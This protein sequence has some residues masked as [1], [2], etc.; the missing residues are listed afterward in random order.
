MP[1][2][3]TDTRKDSL[4]LATACIGLVAAAVLWGLMLD[5][6]LPLQPDSVDFLIGARSLALGHGYRDLSEPG[7]PPIGR[8]I[9]T[10]LILAPI[11]ATLGYDVIAC[12]RLMLALTAATGL[13]LLLIMRQSVTKRLSWIIAAIWCVCPIPWLFGIHVFSEVPYTLLTLAIWWA[14]SS[15][16]VG[17]QAIA[18]WRLGS[19]C[20]AAI[21]AEKTRS[22]GIALWPALIVWGLLHAQRRQLLPVLGSVCAVSLLATS[23]GVAGSSGASFYR[24]HFQIYYQGQGSYGVLSAVFAAVQ[25]YTSALVGVVAPFFWPEATLDF[26]SFAARVPSAITFLGGLTLAMV[27]LVSLL[28]Q[29]RNTTSRPEA[30]FLLV[31]L[32]ATLAILSIWPHRMSRL[33]L[34]VFPFITL[35]LWRS[36]LCLSNA[37]LRS[38][39]VTLGVAAQIFGA[40]S[41]VNEWNARRLRTA[42]TDWRLVANWLS[43]NTPEYARVLTTSKDVFFTSQRYQRYLFTATTSLAELNDQVFALGARYVRLADWQ[44]EPVLYANPELRFIPVALEDS[45]SPLY[46][47][48]PNFDGVVPR[49][50]QSYEVEARKLEQDAERSGRRADDL[51]LSKAHL[52]LGCGRSE[53]AESLLRNLLADDR[54]PHDYNLTVAR[55]QLAD[56]LVHLGR[57]E[58]AIAYY[59][60]ARRSVNADSLHASIVSGMSAARVIAT[61]N[62]PSTPNRQRAEIWQR[63]AEGHIAMARWISAMGAIDKSIALDSWRIESQLLR[64][65]LLR[66]FGDLNGANEQL[67]RVFSRLREIVPNDKQRWQMPEHAAAFEQVVLLR[68]ADALQSKT[69]MEIEADGRKLTVDPSQSRTFLDAAQAYRFDGARGVALAILRRGVERHPKDPALAAALGEDYAAFGE[70]EK[71]RDALRRSIELAPTEAIQGVLSRI[72]HILDDRPLY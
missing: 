8:P 36:V 41:Y 37:K 68:L 40:A 51:I 39:L 4:G 64:T 19:I 49:E 63:I 48:D 62:D 29:S 38:I 53:E 56:V 26:F 14:V 45:V 43:Q 13:I 16:R 61:A 44:S 30:V 27:C 65:R 25:Y 57:P 1:E 67:E 11:A 59:E 21:L 34:P 71:S 31:Y 50:S 35:L 69:A 10:S 66:R 22:Q 32:G 5:D 70:F 72:E 28:R 47:V 46:R 9:G 12:K 42:A 33:L 7:E 17:S 52:L 55:M 23:L 24:S 20:A 2:T 54:N 60:H 58:E 3:G 6:S 15:D 18:P